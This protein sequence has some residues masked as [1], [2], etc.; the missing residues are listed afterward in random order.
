MIDFWLWATVLV[1]LAIVFVLWPVIRRSALVEQADSRETQVLDL[2]NQRRQDLQLQ[3]QVG[4]IEQ[5]QFEQLQAE[6]ELSLLQD[7]AS[8]SMPQSRRGGGMVLIVVAF[9][10]AGLALYFYQERG[11]IDDVDIRQMRDELLALPADTPLEVVVRRQQALMARLDARLAVEPGNLQNWYML[12]RFAGATEQ[13]D[14]AISAYEVI[15]QTE[16]DAP[17]ILSELAQVRFLKSGNSITPEI[18]QLVG[19]ALQV[20]PQDATALGLAGIDAFQQQHFA[21]AVGFWQRAV[22]VLG[23]FSEGGQALQQG[24]ARAKSMLPAD[25]PDQAGADTNNVAAVLEKVEVKVSLAEGIDVPADTVVFVYARAWEGPKMPLAIQ[26][27]TVADLPTTITL[28][29]SMSMVPGMSIAS[30]PALEVVARVS[31]SGS[32]MSQSGDWQAAKG[33]L[34][35]TTKD[36]A[37]ELQIDTKLP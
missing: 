30:F 29:S 32:P 33:P 4:D 22:A 2:Y 15:L 6:N 19:R 24:I 1:G 36:L 28:D 26:R 31:M 8:E 18:R 12:A 14:R 21:D 17:E 5:A 9:I 13:F 35:T 37:L 10:A 20:D 11:A 23:P 7:A 16:P 34:P 27:L 3:L 25:A